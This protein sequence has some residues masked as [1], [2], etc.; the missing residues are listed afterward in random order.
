[1]NLDQSALYDDL[2]RGDGICTYYDENEKM[3]SIY[4]ERPL[5]CRI[6]D[7]YDAYFHTEMSKEVYY[8]KNIEACKALIEEDNNKNK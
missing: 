2:N 5:K 6:D 8:E 3:C 1:M 7:M 4:D